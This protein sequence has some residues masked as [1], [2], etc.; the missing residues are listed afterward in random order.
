M[1][2]AVNRRLLW[3]AVA[4]LLAGAAL[5]VAIDAELFTRSLES[6]ARTV[7]AGMTM[8]EVSVVMGRPPDETTPWVEAGH[9]ALWSR[10]YWFDRRRNYL[11][12]TFATDGR[13]RNPGFFAVRR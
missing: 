9:T 5:A 12:V 4:L 8:D 2:D 13:A 3:S 10:C 7:R 11:A 1:G 6:R